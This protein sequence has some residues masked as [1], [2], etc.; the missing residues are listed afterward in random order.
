MKATSFFK[1]RIYFCFSLSTVFGHLHTNSTSKIDLK[2]FFFNFPPIPDSCV[3][4]NVYRLLTLNHHSSFEHLPYSFHIFE[5]IL[6]SEWL[7]FN[8]QMN[9]FLSA[10][11]GRWD[12]WWCPFCTW[13]TRLVEFLLKWQSMRDMSLQS[14]TLSWFQIN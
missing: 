7:L 10:L 2:T 14:E 8:I 6:V 11:S 4:L 9:I 13:P 1:D 12:E 3:Y 5:G